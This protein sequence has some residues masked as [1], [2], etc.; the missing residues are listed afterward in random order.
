VTAATYGLEFVDEPPA[1]MRAAA[2]ER[3]D[4]PLQV[5]R[6]PSSWVAPDSRRPHG[7]YAKY[8]V[9]LC[10][11]ELCRKA[12]RDYERARQRAISRP[13]QVWV[14]YVPAG[15]ARRHVRELAAAGVGL[16]QVAKISGLPGG[17]LSKLVYG[18]PARRLAP[19]RRIRRETYERIMA[20]RAEDFAGGA[21]LDARPTWDLL[22]QLLAA[23]YTRTWIASKLAGRPTRA[24][25][26]SRRSVSGRN[27]RAVAAL[28]AEFVAVPPPR[29]RTRW[30]T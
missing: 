19:S 7:S 14:P 28:H 5:V 23:G 24:L 2:S 12:K 9:E 22:E 20:V 30:S 1:P 13:D 15:A 17:L 18:D 3:K 16:K 10:R 25:Q 8:T 4:R 21:R 29:R 26:L 27:A 6:A 11:C